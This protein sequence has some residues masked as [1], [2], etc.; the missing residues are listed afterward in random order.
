MSV[1]TTAPTIKVAT[2]GAVVENEEHPLNSYVPLTLV[3][4]DRIEVT[5]NLEMLAFTVMG[6]AAPGA[7][8]SFK[9]IMEKH[10]K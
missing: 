6:L 1:D 4:E 5:F 3:N 7:V 2:L 10:G 8:E 9:R